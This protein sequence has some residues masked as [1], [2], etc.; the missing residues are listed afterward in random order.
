MVKIK[1]KLSKDMNLSYDMNVK[2]PPI[3]TSKQ[4][5]FIKQNVVTT[6]HL[7]RHINLYDLCFMKVDYNQKKFVAATARKKT[8]QTTLLIFASGKIVNTGARNQ[9]ISLWSTAESIDRLKREGFDVEL[10]NYTIE[11]N[12]YSINVG[13]NIDL[14]SLIRDP[15]GKYGNYTPKV[16]PGVRFRHLDTQI[17]FTI[18]NTGNIVVTGVKDTNNMYDL[19]NKMLP[20]LKR[21]SVNISNNIVI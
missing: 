18:F 17:I 2:A 5:R 9:I 19:Y 15:Q 6:C 20:F 3:G 8:P 12:V 10:K 1:A 14:N 13:F 11:N 4:G 21:N 7:N 16:F